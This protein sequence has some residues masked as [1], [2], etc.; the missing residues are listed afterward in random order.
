MVERDL[1]ESQPCHLPD[2]AAALLGGL[3]SPALPGPQ[4]LL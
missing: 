1:G 4:F 2:L 3:K